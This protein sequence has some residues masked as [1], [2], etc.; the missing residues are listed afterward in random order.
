MEDIPIKIEKGQW[1]SVA[2]KAAGYQN[3]PT[4]T[5][6][7]KTLPGLGAT[8]GELKIAKRHSIIIE[9]NVPV[10]LGKTKDKPEYLG[11]YG[12]GTEAKKNKIEKYLKD[13][14]IKY[15]KLLTTP[16]SYHL[17]KEVVQS[18]VVKFDFYEDFFCLFDE[19][20]K[21]IQDIDYRESIAQPI[22]DFFLFKNK[23]FVSATTLE[24][25][26]PKFKE[27]GF[28][29][30]K[31]KP[32]YG[33]KKDI[34]LIVTN[35]FEVDLINKLKQLK[36]SKCICIFLN[37]TDSIDK[38]ANS[39]KLKDQAKIFCSEKSVRKLKKKGYQNVY[40]EIDLPL[41]KYNFFT[42]RFFS[43]VDIEIKERPDILIL[44][45][46]QDANHTMIDPFTESIQIYGR[47]RY[48]K[49]YHGDNLPFNSIT[50]ITDFK[51]DF[52]V[53]TRDQ[54]GS[55]IETYRKTYTEHKNKIEI[56]ND[57]TTQNA[58]QR[59]LES[60]E[61]SKFLDE[62]GQ[63]NYF[64][65]DNFYNSERVK[66]YYSEPK[67]LLEAYKETEHF[68]IEKSII[69][70]K[71]LTLLNSWF[72]TSKRPVK[73][74]R[75]SIIADLNNQKG[76]NDIDS[77]KKLLR[78]IEVSS[79]E[80]G[81]LMVDAYEY[82]TIDEIEKIGYTSPKKIR[83]EIDKAQAKQ[84][85]KDCFY[86]IVDDLKAEYKINDRI[87]KKEIAEFITDIYRLHGID[88]PVKQETT[89]KYCKVKKSNG[90][91]ATFRICS[92]YDHPQP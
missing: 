85:E 21:L 86:L 59:D 40:S 19:C 26:H 27:Q 54:I 92:F 4:N 60:L 46:L 7:K 17:I 20:E 81:D 69:N 10:I 82:L 23:A 35:T 8:Y 31:V 11:I 44:T 51:S 38:V 1:L 53:M 68:K 76:S 15:K 34:E 77:H 67:L 3:I 90:T 50:H 36:D 41:K 29:I 88:I 22:N 65:Q 28:R 89:E 14:N 66:G 83:V 87:P 45:V 49:K 75:Q 58:L 6:L 2:L 61:Y 12:E 91:P 13:D 33:Y 80:M 39:L 78:S 43:A 18:R 30:L 63:F 25:S 48:K 71:P 84:E 9:P 70:D 79:T 42:C 56:T 72:K 62:E 32:T 74:I 57:N 52:E 64:S 5:I 55:T 73:E 24:M 47:F 37:K 16:E